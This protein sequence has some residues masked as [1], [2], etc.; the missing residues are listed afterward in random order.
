MRSVPSENVFIASV[1][2]GTN[3]PYKQ[4]AMSSKTNGWCVFQDLEYVTGDNWNGTFYIGGP[5]GTVYK[6]TGHTDKVT[7]AGSTG[8]A[9]TFSLLT[10]FSDLSESGL[11]HQVQF[12][13]PVFRASAA[14]AYSIS[15]RYD[16][17]TDDYSGLAIASTISGGLW[18]AAIWDTSLW[19]G[20]ATTIESITGG[21]GIGRAVA[22]VLLGTSTG[23][24]NL[25]RIDIMYTTGSFL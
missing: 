4:Y 21:A 11:Y 17:N 16:Y 23:E 15:A 6:L 5:T 13:R 22:A 19:G 2:K 18:D 1:P 3:T 8:N 24:T 20:D 14:P 9:I 12:L 7:L 10:A 25:M